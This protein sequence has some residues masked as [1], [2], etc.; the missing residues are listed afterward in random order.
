MKIQDLLNQAKPC[1]KYAAYDDYGWHLYTRKPKILGGRWRISTGSGVVVS[2]I[3]DIEPFDGD[4]KHS[5][6]ERGG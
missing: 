3:F 4:W 1:W 5:L 2:L 6:I